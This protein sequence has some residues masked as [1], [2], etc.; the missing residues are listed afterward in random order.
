VVCFFLNSK[1]LYSLFSQVSSGVMWVV[2]LSMFCSN[3]KCVHSSTCHRFAGI[4]V[5]KSL[6]LLSNRESCS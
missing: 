5:A 2:W 3:P 1:W 6:R 4:S